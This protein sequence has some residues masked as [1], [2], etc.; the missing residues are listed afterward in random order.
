MQGN[1]GVEGKKQGKKKNLPR[2]ALKLLKCRKRAP[3][4]RHRTENEDVQN[5]SI[6]NKANFYGSDKYVIMFS[7]AFQILSQSINHSANFIR[8]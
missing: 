7:G 6:E 5:H 8:F 4:G 1:R 3:S 2:S